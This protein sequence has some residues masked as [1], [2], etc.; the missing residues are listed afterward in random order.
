MLSIEKFISPSDESLE[1]PMNLSTKKTLDLMNEE[2]LKK[3]AKNIASL[4][5]NI[6][7]EMCK[8]FLITRFAT[9]IFFHKRDFLNRL[10]AFFLDFF[11][12]PTE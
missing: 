8:L 11:D 6:I 12:L 3:C 7:D 4:S 1:V 2:I 5:S 9:E 10:T